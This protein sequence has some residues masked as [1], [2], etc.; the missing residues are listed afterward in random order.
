MSTNKGATLYSYNSTFV[1]INV[2]GK[3]NRHKNDRSKPVVGDTARV[4]L[5][6][7]DEKNPVLQMFRECSLELTDKH[8]RY[9]RIVKISRDITI[10][11]KRIIFLL[12]N[13]NLDMYVLFCI[14]TVCYFNFYVY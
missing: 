14:G 2:S 9:E 10:E 5:E 12:H 8:D 1:K 3:R 11:S 7:I 13:T 4:V 6:Q